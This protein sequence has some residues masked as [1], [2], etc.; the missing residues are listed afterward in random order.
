MISLDVNEK[1][2]LFTINPYGVYL[3]K[4]ATVQFGADGRVFKVLFH[5]ESPFRE[6]EI[7]DGSPVGTLKP[8]A[9]KGHYRYA[10]AIVSRTG[11][12]VFLEPDCPS[13]IVH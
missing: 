11:N 6:Q 4:G 9:P 5:G 2:G 3:S 12:E 8:N 13:I 10:V 7:S 1:K